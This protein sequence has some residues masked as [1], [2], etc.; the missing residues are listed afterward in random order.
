M[1]VT[2]STRMLLL[3]GASL[4]SCP[5]AGHAEDPAGRLRPQA[6]QASRVLH[7]GQIFQLVLTGIPQ[8]GQTERTSGVSH[9]GHI[10]HVPFTASPQ[11]GH[12]AFAWPP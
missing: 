4:A 5:H 8:A 9:T 7:S 1:P 10:F 11:D 6:G 2:G 3:C 12:F